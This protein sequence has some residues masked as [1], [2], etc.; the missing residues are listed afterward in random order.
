MRNNKDILI[1]GPDKGNG[2]VVLD[3]RF[4]MSKIY[5]IVNDESKFLK[6]SSDPKLGS[7]GKLR[8]F[9]RILRNKDFFTKK[10]YYNLYPCSS[11]HSRI[12]GTPKTHKL[13]SPT[14]T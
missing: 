2:V 13:K 10:Q 6:L 5:D 8:R 4:Y 3:R 1:T 14:D 7:V 9:L 11:Q 12:Y